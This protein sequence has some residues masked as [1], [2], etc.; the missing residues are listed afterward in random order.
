MSEAVAK[1]RK[2]TTVTA[3][4]DAFTFTLI[5]FEPYTRRD[6]TQTAIKRWAASCRTCGAAFTVTTPAGVSRY[7]QANAFGVRRCERH[8][9]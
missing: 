4:G 5:G 8:R 1:E 9:R 7:E 2:A 6:G 3:P